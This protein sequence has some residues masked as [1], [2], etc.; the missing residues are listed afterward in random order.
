M[1]TSAPSYGALRRLNGEIKI[2]RVDLNH[3]VPFRFEHGD[4]PSVLHNH[5]L[6]LDTFPTHLCVR[7]DSFG[8]GHEFFRVCLRDTRQRYT[9]F[10][11]DRKETIRGVTA[12][13]NVGHNAQFR[14]QPNT[15]LR[16]DKVQR[17][18][19]TCGITCGKQLLRIR[20]AAV[21]PEFFYFSGLLQ[22]RR[23][24]DQGPAHGQ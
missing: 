15:T 1:L 20:A 11:C 9:E 6:L 16:G 24:T 14:R 3:R 12:K 22:A 10:K 2:L 19:E 17:A 7:A 8:F 5:N 23:R 4:R 21:S 13:R 18:V